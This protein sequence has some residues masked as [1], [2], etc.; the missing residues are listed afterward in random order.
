MTLHTENHKY[1]NATQI[2]YSAE[3]NKDS[4]LSCG[5]ALEYAQLQKNETVVD[6]GSGKG[7]DA[8]KASAFA[9]HVYGIDFTAK[10]VE[11]ARKVQSISNIANVE[12]IH[13]SMDSIALPDAAADV[14]ISNCAIN[15]APD[16]RKVYSEIYRILKPGGRFVVSD[17]ISEE[18]IPAHIA[19]DPEAIAACYGGALPVEEYFPAILNAGFTNIEILQESLPYNKN[20]TMIRSMTLRSYK[21]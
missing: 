12:F 14:V 17:I 1:Q 4:N 15:H 13:S 8:L 18:K 10:M 11:T 5:G 20:G 19:N 3:A 6:L 9:F 21:S 7:N 16:K 2:R